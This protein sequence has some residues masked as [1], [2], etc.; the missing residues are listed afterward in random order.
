MVGVIAALVSGALM[1]IQGVFNTDVTK[2]TSL[3]VSASFVQFTALLVCLAAW[4]ICDRTSFRSLFEIS[5]KYVLLGGAI[6]AF[7]T[8][9]VI[10]SMNGLGPAKAAMLIVISQL[11]V[12]W[13]I[14]L[15]GIFGMEKQPFSMRK[16][17]NNFSMISARVATVPRPPVSP[18]VFAASPFFV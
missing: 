16:L 17:L 8:A 11:T 4:L 13:L 9:T 5:D 2:Q 15:T 3:W 12:A 7:I 6:G 10:W 14:E 18:R 1:S